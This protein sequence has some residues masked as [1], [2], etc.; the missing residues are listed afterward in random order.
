MLQYKGMQEKKKKLHV[1]GLAGK[2]T[3]AVAML[4]GDLGWEISGSDAG[5]YEPIASYLKEHNLI[6]KTPYHPNNIPD[7]VDL[8]LMGSSA[9]LNPETNEEV[10][11]AHQMNVPVKSFAEILSDLTQNTDNMVVAGSYGKST[12]T[13]LLAHYL[14]D[15]G[16]DPS[17]L[18][19]A[20]P[21]NLTTSSKIGSSKYFILEGDEYPHKRDDMK[22]KFEFYHAKSIL[23]TSGEHDHINKFPTLEDYLLPYQR[24]VSL[25]HEDDL[26]VYAKEHPHTEEIARFSKA[27]KVTYGFQDADYTARNIRY[28]EQTYFDLYHRGKLLG[29]LST[30]LLGKHNI[31]NIVGTVA[32]VLEKGILSIEALQKSVESFKGLKRRLDRKTN[33]SKIPVYEGFGSSYTK[34]KTAI[35]AIRLHF[36]HK[37]LITLFEPHTFGWRNRGNLTWYRDV[38][39]GSDVVFIYKPPTHGADSHE[40]LSLDEIVAETEK[41][42]DQV[43]PFTKK[44]EFFP[45]LTQYINEESVVLI[46]T[47]GDMDGLVEE[48]PQF[49]DER[50]V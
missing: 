26:L 48:V 19:G 46:L 21:L 28:G 11:R 32:L 3:S 49:L 29:E 23:L 43:I 22:S 24:L 15:Q 33:K 37:K 6:C 18:I 17:Y 34:A 12:C 45:L 31:E 30:S 44:E 13:S 40:Q 35:E 42:Q 8:I 16:K 38:F 4:M 25:L 50:Y 47:S 5:M 10:A 14:V 1:I 9:T 36:P 2:G 7:D 27:R 39:D 41:G 20:I